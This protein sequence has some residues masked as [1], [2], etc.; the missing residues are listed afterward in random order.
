MNTGKLNKGK[1]TAAHI[2]QSF[3]MCEIYNCG[4]ITDRLDIE[5][6]G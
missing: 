6:N 5:K 4:E 2:G 3:F 1:G